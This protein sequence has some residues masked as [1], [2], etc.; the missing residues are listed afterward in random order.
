MATGTG[1]DRSVHGQAG[2]S[3]RTT[4]L[5]H[6]ITRFMSMLKASAYGLPLSRDSS[7][8]KY[9]RSRSICKPQRR[10]D[11]D[12]RL[13]FEYYSSACDRSRVGVR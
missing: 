1:R 5:K 11:A 6:L 2:S 4:R 13:K 8:A 7:L 9:S 10:S 12:V 3:A